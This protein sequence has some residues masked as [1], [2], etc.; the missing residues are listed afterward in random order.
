M[1]NVEK[2]VFATVCRMSSAMG[3]SGP[4]AIVPLSEI[5]EKADSDEEQVLESLAELCKQ[6][7]LKSAVNPSGE[8]TGYA[9]T[10]DGQEAAREAG[11]IENTDG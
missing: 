4:L 3:V 9:L 7:L 2:K 10:P 8:E 1:D 6:G 5:H 11:L